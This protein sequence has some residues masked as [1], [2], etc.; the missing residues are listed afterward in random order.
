MDN[1]FKNAA[2]RDAR[3]RE[4][5]LACL[6][7]AWAWLESHALVGVDGHNMSSSWGRL[8]TAGLEFAT[9]DHALTKLWAGE[10]LA[11]KFDTVLAGALNNFHFGDYQT[12][13]FAAMKEVEVAVRDAAGLGN[14]LVGVNVMREAFKPQTGPLSD[15]TTEGGEQVATMELFAGAIGAFK[16]P[17]SHRAVDYDDPEEVAEII[18]L[19][20]LLLKIVRRRT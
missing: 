8:T 7:D 18:Q 16:N 2:I 17:N 1:L 9:D 10:R 20:D 4:L 5:L 11:G 12:A 3:D 19:A 13:C 14:N 6:S 15:T